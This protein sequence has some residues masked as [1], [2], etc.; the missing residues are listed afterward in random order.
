MTKR[1][2]PKKAQDFADPFSVML[3][4]DDAKLLT[5]V[6]SKTGVTKSVLIRLAVRDALKRKV[7]EAMVAS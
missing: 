5:T 1:N 4:K 6:S 3:F 7:F 2:T